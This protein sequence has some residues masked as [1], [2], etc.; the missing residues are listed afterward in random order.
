MTGCDTS[1]WK[2]NLWMLWLSQ[3]LVL[4]GFCAMIP[5]V[6]LFM[7]T[8][9]GITD[10][11][12]LAFYVSMFNVFGA[13]AYAIFTPLNGMLGDRFGLKVML[14]RGT[15]VT[16]LLFP[17]MGYVSNVWLLIILRF[18]TA[19]CAGTT[20]ASQAMLGRTV[21]D[22]KQGF[23]L[24]MLTTAYWGGAMLGNVIGGM[25]IHYFDYIAAFLV[26]G[27]M[28]F[29]AGFAILPT[30]DNLVKRTVEAGKK[31]VEK[32]GLFGWFPRFGVGVWI[33][34]ILLLL[35]GI[36]RHF[37]AP[38]V[39]LKIEAITSEKEAAYWTGIVSAVVCVGAIFSGVVTG[40]F[41]DRIAPDKLF[42]PMLGIS[43]VML[44]LQGW[45]TGVW[46][47]CIYRVLAYFVCGGMQPVLLK[48]MA[49]VT[50][51]DQRGAAFGF[52]TCFLCLGGML[53]A[54]FAG[55]AMMWTS[56]DGVFYIGA[57]LLLV[58]IP[59]FTWQIRKVQQLTVKKAGEK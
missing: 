41:A 56:L 39:A 47:F 21:P 17:V 9:L 5:F 34:L 31:V 11:S 42:I 48:L 36:T 7:K 40:Y 43:G 28:Y 14:L 49:S 26:C 1:H 12:D 10:E 32:G 8:E 46:S 54:L 6:P 44:A 19:A 23:A 4:S 18:L 38:F 59:V 33:T 29:V 27:I 20:A 16:A 15:F 57:V 55:W 30:R 3:L 13:G 2:V 51:Q 52:G 50:P 22:N 53:S 45:C 25:V 58:M 35:M 24:G 37:E